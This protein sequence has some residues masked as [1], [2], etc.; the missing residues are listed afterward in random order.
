[1]SG[2]PRFPV[3]VLRGRLRRFQDR[4]S[5][6]G[7]DAA[8]IRTLS[9]FIYFTGTKWLRPA[10]LVPAE[11][12]PVAFVA[13]GEENGFLARTWV[14]EVVTYADGGDLMSK[15]SGRL[16][17]NDYK[18]VGLEFGLERDAYILFYEMFKRLNPGVRVV[19]VGRAIAEMRMTKDRYELEAIRRAGVIATKAMEKALSAIEE[20]ASEVDIAAEAYSVLYKLGSEEPHVYVDAGPDPRVHAE[21]FR[22]SVV[23]KGVF[24]TVV[25]GADYNRYYANISRSTFFGDPV[26]LAEKAAKCME[27]VYIKARELTRPGAR[28]MEVLRALDEVYREYGMLDYRVLGYAHGVGLQIEETP[29]T[30]IVPKDRFADVKERMALAL[31]HAPIMLKGLG[32]VKREDTFIVKEEGLERV[33]G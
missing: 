27:E 28:L 25:I 30:T 18:V 21:P 29:I 8:M 17:R 26:P 12:E 19:D 16:R 31:V 3:R 22:D 4:L 11:G 13:R 5:E 15:V 6:M 9:S 20:G 7:I 2:A 24:V 33:T 1:M 10:L 32:Q 14:E 23:R